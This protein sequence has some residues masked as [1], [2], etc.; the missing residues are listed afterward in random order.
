M[1]FRT[2]P[3]Y[4]CANRVFRADWVGPSCLPLRLL[5]H[6]V[7]CDQLR[8]AEFPG[9]WLGVASSRDFG[10]TTQ[11]GLNINVMRIGITG[12]LGV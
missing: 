11:C 10:N 9:M 5:A 7:C 2:L 3:I 4:G 8:D 6:D 12:A 1:K